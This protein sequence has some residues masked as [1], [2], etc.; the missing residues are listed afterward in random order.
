MLR[1]QRLWCAP[2]ADGAR[3]L[4][5]AAPSRFPSRYFC[6]ATTFTA[7]LLWQWLVQWLAS[8]SLK[9]AGKAAVAF[10]AGNGVSAAAHKLRQRLDCL[11][12]LVWREQ[13]PPQ[14]AQ[15][16]PLLQTAEHLRAVFA[17]SACPPA[18]FQL[19]FQRPLLG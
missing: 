14:S 15:S 9:A 7:S 19:H 2:T 6:P 18:A 17:C 8:A 4:S 3:E 16:D 10:C 12:S 5:L 11:R 13:E 1:G